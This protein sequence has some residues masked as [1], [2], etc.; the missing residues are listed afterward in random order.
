MTIPIQK[1]RHIILTHKHVTGNYEMRAAESYN[2]YYGIGYTYCGDRLIHTPDKT[3]I[4]NGKCLCFIH[5]NLRHKTSSLTNKPY[6]STQ[7][8]ITESIADHIKDLIGE[9]NFE[10]LFSQIV[11]F[12]N[13]KTQQR[14]EQIIKNMEEEWTHFDN[15]SEKILENL[16]YQLIVTCI[17]DHSQHIAPQQNSCISGSETYNLLNKAIPTSANFYTYSLRYLFRQA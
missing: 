5:K 10:Q 12:F 7:L 14:I 2:D 15:Y 8:K 1:G 17:R 6:D 11:F 4:C 13:E 9:E 3:I 16:L